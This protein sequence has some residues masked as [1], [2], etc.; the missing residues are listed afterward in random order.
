MADCTYSQTLIFEHLDGE[1]SF[2]NREILETHLES[3][4]SC[5]KMFDE[6]TSISAT[7]KELPKFEV[8]ASFNEKLFDKIEKEKRANIIP[9][10]SKKVPIYQKFMSY[11]AGVA[12][13]VMTFMFFNENAVDEDNGIN[14][15]PQNKFVTTTMEDSSEAVTQDSLPTQKFDKKDDLA[16]TYQVSGEQ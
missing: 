12:V 7:M 15:V 13:I 1:L 10:K 14:I 8:S 3:C 16:P 6:M 11:A 4:L 9:I 2:E 5:K